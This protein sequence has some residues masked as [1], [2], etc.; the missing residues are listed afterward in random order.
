MFDT[1]TCSATGVAVWLI[2]TLGAGS[3][4]NLVHVINNDRVWHE[5]LSADDGLTLTI[6]YDEHYQMEYIDVRGQYFFLISRVV[7]TYSR[8]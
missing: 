4:L 8:L 2:P 5:T 1:S 7:P 3:K 6:S